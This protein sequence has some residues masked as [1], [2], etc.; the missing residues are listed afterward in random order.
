MSKL[1]ILSLMSL[2]LA[3][4]CSSTRDYAP[5]PAPLSVI[6]PEKLSS[7]QDEWNNTLLAAKKE[8]KV[9]ILSTAGPPVRQALDEAFKRLTGLQLEFTTGRGGEVSAKLLTERRAGLYLVDVYTGGS[10]TSVTTLKPAGILEPIKPLLFLP[11]VINNDAWFRKKLPWVDKEENLILAFSAFPAGAKEIGF[12]SNLVKKEDVS[13]FHLLLNPKFKGKMNMQ[14][15]TSSGKGLKWFQAALLLYPGIDIDFMKALARQEPLITRDKR[16][17]IQWLAQGK[18][19]VSIL[20]DNT[21]ITEFMS[22]GAPVDY[23][24]PEEV[25]PRIATGSGSLALFKDA[26]HPNAARLFINWLLGREGQTIFSR[27]YPSQ[28]ARADIP[29][30]FL[31]AD[32]VRQPG[33][34]YFWETEDFLMG[35]ADK[36]AKLSQEIFGSLLR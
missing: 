28:S 3:F 33:L 12:N 22:L 27:A 1:F 8:G 32:E 11:E 18:Q 26:P 23:L 24:N 31:P 17:Q 10:T 14:D 6:L 35:G 4:G 25:R 9:V 16:L 34:E 13:A 2:I 21:T 5:P 30:D 20:P 19:L 15:P 7:P 29:T 36:A